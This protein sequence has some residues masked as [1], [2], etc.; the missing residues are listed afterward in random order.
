M[1]I[2]DLDSILSAMLQTYDGISDL[3]FSVG[4]PMQVEDFGELKPVFVDPPIEALT[5]Y[6][7]EQIALTLM[8]GN[9]RL[10]YD[11]LT[12]GSCD[13]SY[14]LNDEARFRVSVFRQQG[15]FA[16]VLRKLEGRVP[17]IES[18]QL[19]VVIREI[20]KEK[21]GLVLVTGATGR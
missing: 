15:H 1:R 3:N 6:Q 4:H 17:T 5:P 14:S 16:V 13:C 18:L 11:Y 10:I 12:G 19:P 7:T 9:R 8:Q 2:P 20:A 21:T